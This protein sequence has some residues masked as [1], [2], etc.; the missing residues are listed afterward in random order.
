[1]VPDDNPGTSFMES[2]NLHK[3][4]KREVSGEKRKIDMVA[5][6]LPREDEWENSFKRPGE[7]CLQSHVLP[8]H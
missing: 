3:N 8:Y 7:S 5:L 2:D 4:Y 6:K 1:V